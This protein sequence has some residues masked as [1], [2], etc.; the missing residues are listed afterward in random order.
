MKN[1][2]KIICIILIFT[3]CTDERALLLGNGPSV[4]NI[5]YDGRNREYI[6]YLP[7]D[8]SKGA[9]LIFVC[10]G[11]TGSAKGIMDFSKMN[12]LADKHNFAVCYPQG[13][14][15]NRRNNFWQVGY[16]FNER[17]T[18]DDVAFLTDLAIKLQ[19]DYKLSKKNT[20]ITGMSNGGDICNLLA[21]TSSSVFKATAPVVGC[22]MKWFIESYPDPDPIPMLLI[23]GTA[24]NITLWAG[25]MADE[26]EWGPYHPTEEMFDFWINSNR[27]T[28]VEKELIPDLVKNDGSNVRLEKHTGGDDAEPVW[29]YIVVNGKHDWPG[30][31][32]NRDIDASKVIWEFFSSLIE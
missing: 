11:Y 32:G 8:L 20:F 15:D 31:S 28:E 12:E 14:E 25:D 10:H 22:M 16:S 7:E 30:S 29:I 23:N 9:P 24:D 26:Y 21:C 27:C 5:E 6:V 4:Q 1:V 17:D 19:R 2:A 18:V 3:G 13:T